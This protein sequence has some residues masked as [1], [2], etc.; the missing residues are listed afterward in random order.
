MKK[1]LIVVDMQNDFL[2][3]D[4]K[5][6]LGHDTKKL[7]EEV[8][9]FIKSFDGLLYFTFDNHHEDDCEFK[10]FPKHCIEHTKG[11]KLVDEIRNVIRDKDFE[12]FPKKSYTGGSIINLANQLHDNDVEE[13][14][15]VGVCT[16]ICVHDIVSTI[17]NHS[18]NEHSYLPNIIVHSNL[19]DD[20]NPD[21]AKFSLE[22]MKNLYGAKI[23]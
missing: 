23:I 11:H 14:H 10:T 5:L 3:N 13:I 12:I 16:H 21:M 8:A 20:F 4:G 15:V 17:V 7:R 1:A 19:V 6:N 2:L 22:R 18:K 9:S